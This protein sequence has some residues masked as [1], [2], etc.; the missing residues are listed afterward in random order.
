MNKIVAEIKQ[1]YK[2]NKNEI[3]KRLDEFK[4][5]WETKNELKALHELIFCIFTPQSKAINCWK[6][7]E[8]I[9]EN[10]LLHTDNPEELLRLKEIN[11]VR[12][13]NKKA[14]FMI[15]AKKKFIINGK[16][17]ILQ[18]LS[19]FKN[20]YEMREY[21]VKNIKGYG[22]KEASHFLRNIG[23]F[24][25]VAILDRHILKNLK[26]MKVISK[27]PKTL[28]PK[29]YLEIEQCMK[30]FSKKIKIPM[31]ALDLILWYKETGEFFK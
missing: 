12:F 27:I 28:T 21:L 22:Y 15:E 13:K 6:C 5:I 30:F 19:T 1:I 4:N 17:Q 31:G 3:R 20:V 9:I 14:K 23:F 24:N 26:L 10:K 16:I 11:Y 2:K 29:L 25:D 7:V 8:K 18:F